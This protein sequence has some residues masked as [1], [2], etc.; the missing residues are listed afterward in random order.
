MTKLTLSL[1][2]AFIVVKCICSYW[3]DDVQQGSCSS[4]ACSS[5]TSMWWCIHGRG[6]VWQITSPNNLEKMHGYISTYLTVQPETDLGT[7][8]ITV[9]ISVFELWQ[10]V[11]RKCHL[12]FQVYRSA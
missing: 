7:F 5:H 3:L 10:D 1:R 9:L 12:T 8:R 4:A 6:P 2:H 11:V